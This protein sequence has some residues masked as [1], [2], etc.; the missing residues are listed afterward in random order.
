MG[1]DLKENVVNKAVVW[2][3]ALRSGS[4]IRISRTKV[5]LIDAIESLYQHRT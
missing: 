4:P 3:M 5:D 1:K 2:F